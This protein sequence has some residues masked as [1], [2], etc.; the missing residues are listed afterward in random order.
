MIAEKVANL[1]KGVRADSDLGITRSVTQVEA[2]ELV[3]TTPQAISEG[4]TGPAFQTC[5]DAAWVSKR[6]ETSCRRELL[7]FR[8]HKEV[9]AFDA[10]RAD[11]LLDWC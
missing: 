3:G 1:A 2:A 10:E 8:H 11:A 9:A 6:F 4:W 5:A 7:S